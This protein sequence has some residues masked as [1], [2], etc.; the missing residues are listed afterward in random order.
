MMFSTLCTIYCLKTPF[1]IPAS[2]LLCDNCTCVHMSAYCTCV[3]MIINYLSLIIKV[4]NAP[5]L[6]FWSGK[7]VWDAFG[8]VGCTLCHF[9]R[10]KV[11]RPLH[12]LC[13]RICVGMLLL[14]CICVC[15]CFSICICICICFCILGLTHLV[16]VKKK[17]ISACL[18]CLP[19]HL[20]LLFLI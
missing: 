17:C 7:A 19:L 1:P 12:L 13:I 8:K 6:T 3:R 5:H 18:L 10:G 20:L 4:A 15:V 2:I 16:Q 14:L 9:R 11:N